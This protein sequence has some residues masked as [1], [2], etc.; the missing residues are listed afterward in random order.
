MKASLKRATD[1][2]SLE[3]K[4]TEDL[5]QM[6]KKIKIGVRLAGR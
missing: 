2:A 1:A 4:K 3:T 5:E 6:Q